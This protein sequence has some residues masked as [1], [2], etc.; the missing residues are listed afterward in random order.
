[1]RRKDSEIRC[2]AS[3]HPLSTIANIQDPNHQ[4][5]DQSTLIAETHASEYFNMSTSTATILSKVKDA[6]VILK[7]RKKL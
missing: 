4:I 2:R 5:T 1:M 3:S 6:Q 7:W